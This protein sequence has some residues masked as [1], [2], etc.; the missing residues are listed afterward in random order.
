M[1]GPS[2]EE[3]AERARIRELMNQPGAVVTRFNPVTG[4]ATVEYKEPTSHSPRE[5]IA[6]RMRATG[7]PIFT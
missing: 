1:R 5:E 4:E 3:V 6:A 2:A 7:R